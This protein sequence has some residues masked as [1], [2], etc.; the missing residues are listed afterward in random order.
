LLLKPTK[1]R[2]LMSS[3]LIAL[4]SRPSTRTLVVRVALL[5]LLAALLAA[6]PSLATFYHG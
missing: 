2:F 3:Q 1:G 6:A 4:F 5:C